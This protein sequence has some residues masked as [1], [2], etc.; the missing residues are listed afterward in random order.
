MRY[1]WKPLT[2]ILKI[3]VNIIQIILC[4]D[5]L[6]RIGEV[7]LFPQTLKISVE[8]VG[9]ILF[10]L[11]SVC[12]VLLLSRGLSPQRMCTSIYIVLD[13]ELLLLFPEGTK[14]FAD[15]DFQQY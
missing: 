2:P 14:N 12:I 7:F 9:L 5:I 4:N 10:I 11:I 6:I 8:K 15:A 3:T 1:A 13:V